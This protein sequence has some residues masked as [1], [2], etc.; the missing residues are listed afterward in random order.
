MDEEEKE[1][2]DVE[3]AKADE[4][5]VEEKVELLKYPKIYEIGHQGI[6]KLFEGSVEISEKL[7]G[8]QF[9]ILLY[10]EGWDVGSHNRTGIELIGQEKMFSQAVIQAKEIWEE[11]KWKLFGS[12]IVLFCEFLP[13]YRTNTLTYKRLPKRYLYLF[14]A[15]V[16]GRHLVTSELKELANV[17]GLEPINVMWDGTID[18]KETLNKFLAQESAFGGARVEGIVIKN[19]A[20]T[21]PL[22]LLST[23]RYVGF[24]LAGKLV[25]E[26]F[27]EA[28]RSGW[29]KAK[30]G[31]VDSLSEVFLT[32]PRVKKSIQHLK[33]KGLLS[34][35]KKDL[36]YLIP[37]VWDD[38]MAECG[39]EIKAA[40][41]KDVLNQ[42]K[43]KVNSFTIKQY[44]DYLEE[45]QFSI[46]DEK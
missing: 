19:Y 32:S 17:L 45:K 1:I 13:L 2:I 9:R 22:D 5:K 40:I 42:F 21:Y 20:Q 10:P 43:R 27:K 25:N 6:E 4:K 3:K 35:E 11:M 8:S 37:E 14:G 41:L 12:D 31:T 46:E 36:Q 15:I 30:K 18:N 23:S 24:P 34:N 16:N 26:E 33:E 44:I 7:D 29:E 28:N 39:D 38:L